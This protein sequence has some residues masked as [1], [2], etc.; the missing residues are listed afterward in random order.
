MNSIFDAGEAPLSEEELA[1]VR[2][3]A[4]ERIGLWKKRSIY[5]GTVFFLSCA[6]VGPFLQG[7]PLHSYWN[8]FSKYL[9]LLSM[10]LLVV[11]VHCAG[12]LWSAW[13][14]LRDV[15]KA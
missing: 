12:F 10:G 15:T 3:Y 6:S 9:V 4:K 2:G 1:A 13:M 5:S 14:A 11:F 8:S 7:H